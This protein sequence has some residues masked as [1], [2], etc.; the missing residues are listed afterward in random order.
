MGNRSIRARFFSANRSLEGRRTKDARSTVRHTT[1]LAG[2]SADANHGCGRL[3]RADRQRLLAL[4][5]AAGIAHVKSAKVESASGPASGSASG[6]SAQPCAAP[7]RGGS[8]QRW[9]LFGRIHAG[10]DRRRTARECAGA[11]G[12]VT[13]S[14]APAISGRASSRAFPVLGAAGRVGWYSHRP[15]AGEPF[16]PD[17]IDWS[18]MRALSE[19]PTTRQVTLR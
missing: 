17:A 18:G 6:T 1:A 14:I 8:A 10:G 15:S 16:E 9:A 13:E 2:G 3:P 4:E 12:M 7:V 11:V 19:W 5:L